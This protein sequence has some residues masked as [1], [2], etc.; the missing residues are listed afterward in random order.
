[1]CR[2]L[3]ATK[4]RLQEYEKQYSLLDLMHHLEKE[5]G[6][7]GNGLTLFSNKAE[8]KWKSPKYQAIFHKKG[9]SYTVEEVLTHIQERI[10][11]TDL[12][13]F[14]TRIASVGDI[15]DEMCHPFYYKGKI[16]TW[17]L[18]T[19]DDWCLEN[20]T[21]NEIWGQM[22]GTIY[23][24]DQLCELVDENDTQLMLR[25]IIGLPEAKIH[26][27]LI[28]SR[29]VWTCVINGVPFV[30]KGNGSLT[31]WVP[32]DERISMKEFFF[33]SSLPVDLKS[34]NS[35][36]GYLFSFDGTKRSTKKR[37]DEDRYNRYDDWYYRNQ[38]RWRDDD[39][40]RYG[41]TT[42]S[43]IAGIGYKE[44][45]MTDEDLLDDDDNLGVEFEREID[46]NED[47]SYYE[48]FDA[49]YN[50]GYTNGVKDT[51]EKIEAAAKPKSKSPP[52]KEE[53]LAALKEHGIVTVQS[54]TPGQKRHK[55]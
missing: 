5:C 6:G 13:M 31:E 22:N 52:T 40:E 10:A 50:V 34:E 48:G 39:D 43:A 37:L 19:N 53:R 20:N 8:G 24:F 3:L 11:D 4:K 44:D 46:T 36:L 54:V 17:N 38:G 51:Q 9:M 21:E 14:H 28:D 30:T 33:V 29:Q 7:H 42:H 18:P 23:D 12:V 25:T 45:V 35:P 32:R 26:K 55:M 16:T 15:C 49:G 2:V 1:M 47:P 41:L 27:A